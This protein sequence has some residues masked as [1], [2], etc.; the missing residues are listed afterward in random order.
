MILGGAMSLVAQSMRRTQRRL[1]RYA[2]RRKAQRANRLDRRR[3]NGDYEDVQ[4]RTGFPC[5]SLCVECGYFF[6]VSFGHVDPA[7]VCPGCGQ[8]EWIDL[9]KEAQIEYLRASEEERR[10]ALPPTFQL[11][12]SAAR[13]GLALGTISV[14]V[15]LL[16][17]PTQLARDL[18]LNYVFIALLIGVMLSPLFTVFARPIAVRFRS[19]STADAVRWHAPFLLGDDSPHSMQAGIATAPE[20]CESPLTGE[21][22]IAYGIHVRFD[23][24]GDSRPPQ[25][26]LLEQEAVNMSINDIDISYDKVIVT[27]SP[28]AVAMPQEGTDDYARVAQFLRQRG[29][30]ISD[31]EFELFEARFN[32]GDEVRLEVF[33]ERYAITLV[34]PNLLGR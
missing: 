22:C 27:D 6:D 21:R 24:P 5:A 29:L 1:D 20:T 2:D 9:E 17:L 32:E 28:S 18:Y 31:G 23:A 12:V 16:T 7:T 14:F 26:V 25:W 11:G 30:F 33:G 34:Q 3:S 19:G 13:W 15:A 4:E 10:M 8:S